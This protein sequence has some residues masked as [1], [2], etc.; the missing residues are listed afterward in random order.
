MQLTLLQI[1]EA[2]AFDTLIMLGAFIGFILLVLLI[3]FLVNTA[4]ENR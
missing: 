3:L 2:Q 1:N 4:V